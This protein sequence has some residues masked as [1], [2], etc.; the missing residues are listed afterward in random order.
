MLSRRGLG[1]LIVLLSAASFGVVTPLARLAY[2]AGVNVV[3]VM[4]VRYALAGLA[5]MGYLVWHRQ[6]WALAGRPLGLTLGLALFLGV[7]SFTYLRSIRYIPVSLAAL[8]YYTY[9]IMVSL[10]AHVTGEDRLADE[11]RTVY[12]ITLGGQAL[13]LAGLVL[14]L[15]LS[16]NVL[17]VAGVLMAAFSA[18]SFTIVMV[19]G[20]RLMRTVPPMVLNLYVALVNTVFFSIA[21]ALG[22]G[23]AWPTVAA[24]WI[25]LMGAAVFFVLGFLGLFVGVTMI[26]PS[27]A[28][29]LTNVE[30]VVTIALAITVLSEPFSAWQFVG[31]AAVLIGIFTMCR[32]MLAESHL[33][34]TRWEEIGYQKVLEVRCTPECRDGS[35]CL[36]LDPEVWQRLLIGEGAL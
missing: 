2:D 3:T 31:A 17:N 20:S 23:S 25:G 24:G 8:I 27:R 32:S 33:G 14:L 30:P 9:P 19:S 21:G 36:L 7:M 11:A 26:G 15:G 12:L 16:W 22:A 4:V 1:L 6:P 13:S 28:A 29:C 35:R 10:V 18:V 5:V 34:E